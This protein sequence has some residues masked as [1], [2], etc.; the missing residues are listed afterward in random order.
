MESLGEVKDAIGEWHDWVELESIAK[1][2]LDHPRCQLLQQLKEKVQERFTHALRIAENMRK[3]YVGAPKRHGG[4]RKSP[5]RAN[6]AW[7]ATN[8]LAA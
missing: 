5:G 8:A 6:S 7:S 1:A 4:G 3:K 2:I